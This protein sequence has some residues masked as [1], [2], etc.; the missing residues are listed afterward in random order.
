MNVVESPEFRKLLILASRAPNLQDQDIPHRKK[1]TKSIEELYVEEIDR[2]KHDLQHA[3][4]RISVTSDLWGDPTLRSYMGVTAHYI[5]KEGYLAEHLIA[6]RR[7]KGEH[8]GANLGRVLFSI[9]EEFGILSKLGHITLD[10]ASNNDTLMAELEVVF[11]ERGLVTF[12]RTLNRI[13]CFPH[14]IN[15]CV[16]T[17]LKEL[18]KAAE[19]F[20]DQ[21]AANGDTLDGDVLDYLLAL[22]SCVVK[23]VRE[24][25]EGMR[26]SGQRRD[27][28][29]ES[30]RLGNLHGLFKDELG[31][32]IILPVLQL[33]R[34]SKTRWSSTY[35]MIERYLKLY[36]AVLRYT[37]DHPEM[38]ITIA[39]LRQCEVLRD[40]L[41]V[42]SLLH[43][44]QELLSAERT[45]TL[46]LALPVYENLIQALR[47][48]AI[49]FP[50][51]QHAIDCGVR[52]LDAYV[53][54]TRGTPAYALAM[55]INPCLKFR[56]IDEHWSR[57]QRNGARVDVREAML[58]VRQDIHRATGMSSIAP[59]TSAD[60]AA[61]H[62]S[63]GYMRLLTLSGKG[64]HG[65]TQSSSLQQTSNPGSSTTPHA[66]WPLPQPHLSA[67][68]LLS[69]H[70]LEVD[71]ELLRWEAFDQYDEAVMGTVNLVDFW[72]AQ[73]YNFP[74]LYQV[75]MDI[76]P[77]QAS[78]VS[79]ERAFSSSKMT[80]TRERST[81]SAEHLEHLQVIKHSLHRRRD[82]EGNFQ[83][84][85][86]MAHVVEPDETAEEFEA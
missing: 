52:K 53:A 85:D 26:K 14:V 67:G 16:N 40:I 27:G 65:S 51:L 19:W 5:N 83:T 64:R 71:T 15:L 25:V 20:R 12:G 57:T 13:R 68:D 43:S 31:E 33:L 8:S 50:M 84:L 18:P 81:I 63:N 73:R 30:T 74:L 34:D 42:L 80:C 66:P 6:F 49:E 11:R 41:S 78:S 39:S 23:T 35:N 72:K 75:A 7:V 32:S 22:E 17:I 54:Q 2:I 3:R 69:R 60:R 55:A 79:S 86:F 59:E 45:P 48:R 46:A 29:A 36:P 82:G 9:F 24:S 1:A 47:N 28:F 77:V 70:M 58:R 10:N 62:Q 21:A 37:L 76:L 61:R 38:N 56:W 44:A 4:G